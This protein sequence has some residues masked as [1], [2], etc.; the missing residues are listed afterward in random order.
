MTVEELLALLP[1]PSRVDVNR[2]IPGCEGV[3]YQ[4]SP[5]DE[6]FIAPELAIKNERGISLGSTSVV[7]IEAP[8]AVGKSMLAREIAHRTRAPLWDLAEFNVGTATFRGTFATCFDPGQFSK[9]MAEIGTGDYLVVL[10]ALDEGRLRARDENFVAFLEVLAYEL[11]NPRRRPVVVVLGR[12]QAAEWATAWFSSVPLA[13]LEISFFDEPRANAFLDDR[14]DYLFTRNHEAPL[15]R[16]HRV[17]YER[18]RNTLFRRMIGLLGAGAEQDPWLR[19]DVRSLLGYAPVLVGVAEFFAEPNYQRLEQMLLGVDPGQ[20]PTAAWKLL[21]SVLNG[22]LDRERKKVVNLIKG[23]LAPVARATGFDSTTVE[24]DGKEVEFWDVLYTPSE[25]R[26]RLLADLLGIHSEQ[27]MD[28]DIVHKEAVPP[29]FRDAYEESIEGQ[30]GT[31]PFARGENEFAG[32]VFRDDTFAWALTTDRITEDQKGIM[33]SRLKRRD[34]LPSSIFAHSVLATSPLS[35]DTQVPV[36]SSSDF[37]FVHE[38]LC[39]LEDLELTL[40][41]ENESISA[42]FRAPSTERE[43][44]PSHEDRP[45]LSIQ[46]RPDGGGVLFPRQLASATINVSIPVSLGVEDTSF[47]LGPNVDIDCSDLRITDDVTVQTGGDQL[48]EGKRRVILVA[49]ECKHGHARIR[50]EGQGALV[51]QWPTARYPWAKF[52]VPDQPKGDDITE[53]GF[54][55]VDALRAI[56]IRRLGLI[57]FGEVRN[58]RKFAVVRGVLKAA[59][60]LQD[61]RTRPGRQMA[62]QV[63]NREAVDSDVLG[64]LIRGQSD[65]GQWLLPNE[66]RDMLRKAGL[67][68][69]T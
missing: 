23:G 18:A 37:G 51:V 58:Q 2:T 31:H 38:S 33:R 50:V 19:R 10:D 60:I 41:E 68:I 22:I 20:G 36:I 25:Q 14:L 46:V 35:A 65:L 34:Y 39:S 55:I 3:R 28:L 9:L 59:G 21:T 16:N 63:E 69:K 57:N 32:V 40:H 15:H 56:G 11:Q 61:P 5:Q 27:F 47:Y 66:V 53:F 26:L 13:H 62:G 30:I 42:Q 52:S 24:I 4:D 44:R 6:P 7:V 48:D 1:R 49:K 67:S 12:A 45:S 8:G 54:H 43:R 29:A 64:W 17:P